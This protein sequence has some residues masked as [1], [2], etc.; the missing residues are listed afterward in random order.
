MKS[1]FKKSILIFLI[2]SVSFL[3]GFGMLWAAKPAPEK[4]GA[5]PAEVTN[6]LNQGKVRKIYHQRAGI[7]L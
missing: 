2:L 7:L 3:L 6:P 1:K 4:E 5:K